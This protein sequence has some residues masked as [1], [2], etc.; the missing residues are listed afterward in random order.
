MCPVCWMSLVRKLRQCRVAFDFYN[1]SADVRGKQI[2]AQTLHE[3]LEYI[4]TQRGVIAANIYPGMVS[5][6]STASRRYM[7]PQV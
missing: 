1:A 5:M 3:M 6:V 4:T 2:K 7:L